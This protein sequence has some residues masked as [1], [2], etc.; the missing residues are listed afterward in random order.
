MQILRLLENEGHIQTDM[1]LNALANSSIQL[2]AANAEKASVDAPIQ[3]SAEDAGRNSSNSAPSDSANNPTTTQDIP[4]S[5]NA[6]VN[7][8]TT[9]P[10]V[11]TTTLPTIGSAVPPT[12]NPVNLPAG[13]TAPFLGAPPSQITASS[14]SITAPSSQITA[15]SSQIPAPS[16]QITAPSLQIPAPSSQVTAP[17][18]TA[19]APPNTSTNSAS[20]TGANPIRHA[21]PGTKWTDDEMSTVIDAVKQGHTLYPGDNE[22]H[23]MW[24]HVHGDYKSHGFSRSEQAI[25]VWWNRAGRQLSG[26]DERSQNRVRNKQSLTTSAQTSRKRKGASNGEHPSPKRTKSALPAGDA[27]Q[28]EPAQGGNTFHASSLLPQTTTTNFSSLP[29]PIASQQS[30]DFTTHQTYPP[31]NSIFNNPIDLLSMYQPLQGES[32]G[33]TAQPADPYATSQP[34]IPT[35]QPISTS[36]AVPSGDPFAEAG[37]YVAPTTSTNIGEASDEFDGFDFLDWGATIR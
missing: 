11:P 34:Y 4:P 12:A 1:G 29:P 3:P 33:Y 30:D 2:P 23:K 9:Q 19:G 5:D 28:P 15:P 36:S 37:Q 8:Q 18:A 7:T 13:S 14:S 26:F 20:N 16:S 10:A 35:A 25:R 31:G 32:Y 27:Q 21:G 17:L 6:A 22:K 24:T